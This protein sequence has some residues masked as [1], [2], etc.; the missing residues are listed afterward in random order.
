LD[1]R[2]LAALK[3]AAASAQGQAAVAWTAEIERVKSGSPLPAADDSQPAELQRLQSI[4]RRES[5]KQSAPVI[6]PAAVPP[7]ARRIE[8]YFMAD[9]AA[10]L[11]VNGNPA[12]PECLAGTAQEAGAVQKADLTLKPGDVLGFRCTSRGGQ[13]NF[14]LIAR[15]GVLPLFASNER[16]EA[17]VEADDAWLKGEGKA[18]VRPQVLR[19][20]VDYNAANAARFEK[21]AR[22]HSADYSVL[23]AG[24][25]DTAAFRYRIR[26]VDLPEKPASR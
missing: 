17:A 7:D 16:W 6:T 25:G 5:E 9:D 20:R 22:A 12:S 24:S 1:S 23:W 8:L 4:Y 10:V 15:S 2:Y 13:R 11:L 18:D 14:C 21:L 26:P 19:G 3:R